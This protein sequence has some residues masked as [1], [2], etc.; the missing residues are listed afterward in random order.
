MDIT[1]TATYKGLRNPPSGGVLNPYHSSSYE[2]NR[3]N[4]QNPC[5]QIMRLRLIFKVDNFLLV[6]LSGYAEPINVY[7]ATI[8]LSRRFHTYKAHLGTNPFSFTHL[9]L[10]TTFFKRLSI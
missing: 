2:E 9:E 8:S 3:L 7:P 10:V 5:V 6:T 4:T 1:L